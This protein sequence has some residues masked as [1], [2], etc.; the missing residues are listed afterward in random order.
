[1]NRKTFCIRFLIVIFIAILPHVTYAQ[2]VCGPVETCVV[3][4]VAG[5]HEARTCWTRIECSGSPTGVTLLPLQNSSSGNTPTPSGS[6]STVAAVEAEAKKRW[7]AEKIADVPRFISQC[8]TR[9]HSD[10]SYS[11]GAICQGQTSQTRTASMSAWIF[12]GTVSTTSSC[13]LLELSKRDAAISKCDSDAANVRRAL[14]KQCE[15]L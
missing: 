15:G 12:G 7:C 13:S 8:K 1:L 2:Q 5:G 3:T 10:Y 6:V 9:A 4:S 11:L 14:D